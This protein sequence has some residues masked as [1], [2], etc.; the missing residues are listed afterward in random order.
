MILCLEIGPGKEAD[1]KL[2]A[3][4]RVGMPRDT[5]C[6]ADLGYLGLVRWFRG[7]DVP[8]R[9]PRQ[10]RGGALRELSEAQQAH[11]A[12]QRRE[13]VGIE[14]TIRR[15]KVFALLS[16]R[17]RNRR[18][19]FGLRANLIAALVNRDTHYRRRNAQTHL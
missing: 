15:L 9:K 5:R 8:H 4:S 12:R 13:R 14:H 3:R 6:L 11:N 18:R 10:S 1:L 16:Q 19:R 7:A 17:Y 2:L